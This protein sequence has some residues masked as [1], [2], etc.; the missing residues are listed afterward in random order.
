M[1]DNT[2]K[3]VRCAPLDLAVIGAIFHTQLPQSEQPHYLT[4]LQHI[5][6]G[7]LVAAS[8]FSEARI[9]PLLWLDSSPSQ[10]QRIR[11]AYA[12]CEKVSSK[13]YKLA[14]W[15]AWRKFLE[16]ELRCKTTNRKMKWFE[17]RPF[18]RSIYTL[19]RYGVEMDVGALQK[20]RREISKI[21]GSVGKG[22]E[23]ILRS[24][25]YG[26]G[27]TLSSADPNRVSLPFKLSDPHTITASAVPVWRDFTAS[28]LGYPGYA[29]MSYDQSQGLVRWKEDVKIVP[30][31][32]I[33]FVDKT[34]VVK[35]TIAIEPSANVSMQLAIHRYLA[36]RLKLKAGI[37]IHDQSR[38]RKLA[39][40]GSFGNHLATIDLSSASDSICRELV[41]QFLPPDWHCL[42]DSVRSPSGTYRDNTVVFE[43]FSSSGNGF[44][45][46]LETIIF[47]AIAKI[48]S[49]DGGCTQKPCVYGD[50]IIVPSSVYHE[51]VGYLSF[52][53]FK[54]NSK[55]SFFDGPFRES[56]GLDAFKGVDVRPAFVRSLIMTVP[57][58]YACHNLFYRKGQLEVCKYL[59][60]LIPTTHRFYGPFGPDAGFL[61]TRD[62]PKLQASRI[63]N[64]RT[65]AWDYTVINERGL[66]W[67]TADKFWLLEAA[68]MKGGAYSDGAPLRYKT[69]L[70]LDTAS[71]DY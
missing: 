30:G 49:E 56:C 20:I 13:G 60:S 38:N 11:Q 44:T 65:F 69:V 26:K 41:R 35:R 27:T 29:T 28:M 59:E 18:R 68:L 14:E 53:G 50:D 61:F 32:R 31:C 8:T 4:Y 25:E 43:K 5:A 62:L 3:Y 22:Y 57:E 70:V 45:F 19:K 7:D 21:L 66:K 51:V 10:Y 12:L 54:V 36:K 37:D 52:F 55:K 67:N 39:L 6:E 58:M 46:A 1:T 47:Y 48:A 42:F 9:D 23:E 63:Y 40:E 64:S 2:I 17:H 33:T 24:L 16:T 71:R 15:R 34:S